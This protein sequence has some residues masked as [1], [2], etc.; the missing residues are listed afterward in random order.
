MKPVKRKNR[1]FFWIKSPR[2]GER[3]NETRFTDR[4]QTALRLAQEASAELGHG[5]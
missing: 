5:M 1:L 3:L 2:R 4:A